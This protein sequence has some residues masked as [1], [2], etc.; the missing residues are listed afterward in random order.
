MTI[1]PTTYGDIDTLQAIFV[2]AR[3]LMAIDGNPTQWEDGYPD[4]QQLE[5][6]VL[7]GVSYVVEQDGE[8]CATFVFIIGGDPTYDIIEDGAWLDNEQLYG[9]I[10]RIA[11]NQRIKGVFDTVLDWCTLHCSNLRIDTHQDN[12]RMIHLIEKAGF[13]RC[14]IIYTRNHSPRIAYQRIVIT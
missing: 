12:R 14:G 13:C 9:T 10:H 2:R 6:D 11:S 4:R 1:R 3:Q 7:R 5:E 8:V